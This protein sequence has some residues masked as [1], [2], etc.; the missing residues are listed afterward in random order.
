VVALGKGGSNIDANTAVDHIFGFGV[1]I[2]MTARGKLA[3]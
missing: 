1:G 2:D 3:F